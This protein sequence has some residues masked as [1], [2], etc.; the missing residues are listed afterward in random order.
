MP[1]RCTQSQPP[2]P[3]TPPPVVAAPTLPPRPVERRARR[4]RE[5]LRHHTHVGVM[6]A[7]GSALVARSDRSP[8]SPLCR[9]RRFLC[10]Q[11]VTRVSQ[12]GRAG[13]VH[14]GARSRPHQHAREASN[15]PGGCARRASRRTRVTV[16]SWTALS[17]ALPRT[18]PSL[19]LRFALAAQARAL[20][21]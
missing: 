3:L 10:M 14:A 12:R 5:F 11:L 9:R 8:F 6:C 19:T 7:L 4:Y 17:T 13:R 16:R 15:R 1:S 21:A 2:S 20:V 18:A